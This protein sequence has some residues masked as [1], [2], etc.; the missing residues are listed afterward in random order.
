MPTRV[1][2]RMEV[3]QLLRSRRGQRVKDQMIN[4]SLEEIDRMLMV[5]DAAVP[6]SGVNAKARMEIVEAAKKR[7]AEVFEKT[8]A[9]VRKEWQRKWVSENLAKLRDEAE[10]ALAE[11]DTPEEESAES[12]IE[13][14][15]Q[16]G[17]WQRRLAGAASICKGRTGGLAKLP[18]QRARSQR[19]ICRRRREFLACVSAV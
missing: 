19:S 12:T 2:T 6:G 7:V 15:S 1:I 3:V 4:L 8:Q 16:Q 11:E 14:R 9:A 5:Y 13:V 18:R 10:A 17:D